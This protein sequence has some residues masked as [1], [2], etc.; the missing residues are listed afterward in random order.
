M[1]C[2]TQLHC[3]RTEIN[4]SLPAVKSKTAGRS[5]FRLG[6][7]DSKATEFADPA[8]FKLTRNIGHRDFTEFCELNST[9]SLFMSNLGVVW[10][11]TNFNLG[12]LFNERE[13]GL[14]LRVL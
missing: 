1:A 7:R 12:V 11:L 10:K 8:S 2:G 4:K 3:F 13:S 14:F 6:A 5:C 9:H